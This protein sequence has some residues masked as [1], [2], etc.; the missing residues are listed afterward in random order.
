ALALISNACVNDGDTREYQNTNR[1]MILGDFENTLSEAG[2]SLEVLIN[3]GNASLHSGKVLAAEGKLQRRQIQNILQPVIDKSAGLLETYGI[4]Y[5][6]LRQELGDP[7]DP[8]MVLIGLWL[9]EAERRSLQAHHTYQ[10]QLADLAFF[11]QED[12]LTEAKPDWMECM[13]VAVGVDAI[14][15]FA[16]GNV[17]EAI[18]K[19]AIR[20]IASRTLGW[21]GVALALYE[22]GNC[23]EWY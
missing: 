17:T 19:K 15:E 1:E 9:A 11:F 13:L 23:M 7:D 22:Y 10:A 8:R 14:I 2:K 21:V 6:F 20:K 18:A 3:S 5:A 12:T 4:S 16:K